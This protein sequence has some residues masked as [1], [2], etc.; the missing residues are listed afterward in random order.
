MAFWDWE[1]YRYRQE[2]ILL[3]FS[4]FGIIAGPAALIWLFNHDAPPA[5]QPPFELAD[6]TP[7]V[8]EPDKANLD[9]MQRDF[10]AAIEMRDFA[11]AEQVGLRIL[12][13]RPDSEKVVVQLGRMARDRG[14]F[15]EA[16][17]IYDRAIAVQS[18]LLPYYIYQKTLVL[19]K[20]GRFAEAVAEIQRGIKID[21]GNVGLNNCLMLAQLEAGN[22]QGVR[23]ELKSY[24]MLESDGQ[25]SLWLLGQAALALRDGDF[26][27]ARALIAEFQNHVPPSVCDTLL[28]DPFFDQYRSNPATI[29][30][31]LVSRLSLPENQPAPGSF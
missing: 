27:Q 30:Y 5:Y 13:A 14:K 4:V 19:R 1:D 8:S 25:K 29:S 10:D 22:I 21:P 12:E 28:N 7:A 26:E 18:P 23:D 17:G 2:R 24:A 16:I 9:A 20:M 11:T 3:I 31:L 15:D 6:S